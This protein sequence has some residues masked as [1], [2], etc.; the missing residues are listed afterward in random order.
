M[1]AL[2]PINT[3]APALFRFTRGFF[4]NLQLENLLSAERMFIRKVGHY[5][6]LAQQFSPCFRWPR[7]TPCCR[8][9]PARPLLRDEKKQQFTH[10]RSARLTLQLLFHLD[11]IG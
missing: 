9:R 11:V 2:S 1:S 8:G 5:P 4:K 3:P 6:G 10:G 7:T